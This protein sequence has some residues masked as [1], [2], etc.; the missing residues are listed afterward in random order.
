MLQRSHLGCFHYY[1]SWCQCLTVHYA[2]LLQVIMFT[3]TLF[4]LVCVVYVCT[5]GSVRG[6][7]EERR[8]ASAGRELANNYLIPYLN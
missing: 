8:V 1:R 4:V 2:I 7:E 5:L 3:R 6:D